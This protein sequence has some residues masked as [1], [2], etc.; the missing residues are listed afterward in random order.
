MIFHSHNQSAY[1]NE[2]Q[3]RLAE[4]ADALLNLAGITTNYS[5]SSNQSTP[6]KRPAPPDTEIQNTFNS[7]YYSLANQMSITHNY[8]TP[9]KKQKSRMLRAK[10]KKKASWLR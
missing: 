1:E 5:S 9:P 2:E 6:V 4:G 8:S 10:L 7:N 3:R